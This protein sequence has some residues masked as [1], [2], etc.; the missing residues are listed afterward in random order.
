MIISVTELKTMLTIRGISTTLTDEQLTTLINFKTEELAGLICKD[1][2]PTIHTEFIKGFCEDR[3]LLDFYSV[4]EVNYVCLDGKLINKKDYYVD[5]DS[6]VVFFNEPLSGDL[7]IEYLAALPSTIISRVV[8]PLIVDMIQYQ[9][10]EISRGGV[11]DFS[12]VKEGDVQ[13]NYN[14]E[15]TLG[16]RINNRIYELKNFNTCRVK[17][18]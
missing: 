3:I 9:I 13:V 14:S 1:I 10:T 16:G 8:V 4:Q 5:H 6:G 2:E 17:V 15:T 12:S 18:L 11:G 7:K